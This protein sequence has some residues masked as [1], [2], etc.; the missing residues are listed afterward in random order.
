V[1]VGDLILRG[2]QLRFYNGRLAGLLVASTS[3]AYATELL[4]VLQ[5]QY[6][7]GQPA[8]RDRVVWRGQ[9]VTLVY[10]LLITNKG[11][12]RRVESVRQ[13]Q[14]SLLSNA[15]WAEAEAE[16]EKVLP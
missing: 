13:G 8:G 10:E 11:V 4:R 14:V 6:G 9:L 12:S 3:E 2:L 15:L 16:A 5:A 7:P 1:V